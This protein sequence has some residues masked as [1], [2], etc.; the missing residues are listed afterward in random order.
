MMLSDDLIFWQRHFKRPALI[1]SMQLG[2]GYT[3]Q[4]GDDGAIQRHY[5]DMDSSRTFFVQDIKLISQLESP[6]WGIFRK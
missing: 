5:Y 4:L 2:K 3:E 6:L 1:S